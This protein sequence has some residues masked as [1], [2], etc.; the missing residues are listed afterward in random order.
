MQDTQNTNF[1]PDD[2]DPDGER[3]VPLD[4]VDI[5]EWEKEQTKNGHL[6]LIHPE[7]FG[8]VV[9]K[10]ASFNSKGE[11]YIA[12]LWVSQG[13]YQPKDHRRQV[14]AADQHDLRNRLQ[15]LIYD[16]PAVV[17]FAGP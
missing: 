1:D 11:G 5:A 15:T 4:I 9:V 3:E 17:S 10:A 6:V 13:P 2:A 12:D 7:R 8:K 16:I 14:A